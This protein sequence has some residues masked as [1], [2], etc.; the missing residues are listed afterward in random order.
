MSECFDRSWVSCTGECAY[1]YQ[2]AACV[3]SKAWDDSEATIDYVLKHSPKIQG[4][5]KNLT[6]AITKYTAKKKM[7][8]IDNFMNRVD[9]SAWS[10]Y[11]VALQESGGSFAV[12]KSATASL[13]SSFVG[14]LRRRARSTLHMMVLILTAAVCCFVL[15]II[16]PFVG[17]FYL[18]EDMMAD[19]NTSSG[20]L[21]YFNFQYNM[22]VV[23]SILEMAAWVTTTMKTYVGK[24]FTTETLLTLATLVT[25][26]FLIFS[27]VQYVAPKF[28]LARMTE[29]LSSWLKGA[30]D[31]WDEDELVKGKDGGL[32]GGHFMRVYNS[33]CYPS[34]K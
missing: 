8:E 15:L 7:K 30:R 16:A 20:F 4:A 19:T 21:N 10:V 32:L 28:S 1:A 13:I 9:K 5:V 25:A 24:F 17:L 23:E 3:P 26:S 2:L 29:K 6:K 34:T 11:K 22:W 12:M 14:T 27:L 33:V 18:G 31:D